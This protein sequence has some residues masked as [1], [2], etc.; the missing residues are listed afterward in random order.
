MTK[1]LFPDIKIKKVIIGYS[2]DYYASLEGLLFYDSQDKL[3]FEIGDFAATN[4]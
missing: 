1:H 2:K 4:T 3:I